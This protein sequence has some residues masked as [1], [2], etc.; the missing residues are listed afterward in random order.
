MKARVYRI[1]IVTTLTALVGLLVMQIYWFVHAYKLEEAQFDKSVNLA[2]RNVADNLLKSQKDF[3]GRIDPVQHTASNAFF[4]T[5][6]R[7]IEYALLDSLIRSE[8]KKHGIYTSFELGVYEHQS[9]V[10]LYGNFY[11]QGAL[12]E[13][14]ATC[15]NREP[16]VAKMDFSITFPDK[17]TDILGSLNIWI[18]TAAIFLLVLVVFSYMVM[19]L[20]KQKKLAEIKTDF[21]NNMTHELQTPIANIG[22]ASE[23]LRAVTPVDSKKAMRYAN[24]IHEEN[25]RL[26]FHVEQ[27]L[28]TAQ[29]ERGEVNLNKKEIDINQLINSVISN[30]ELRL[31]SRQGKIIKHLLA[32]PAQL[33]GDPFHLTN[34]FYNLLDN[35]DKYSPLNPEITI[36][37]RNHEAGIQISIADK[38]IGIKHDVQKFIF[39][40]FYRAATG[41]QHDIKGFGLGLTYVQQ[42]VK[43]HNG[44]VTVSSEENQGSRFDLYFQ[45]Y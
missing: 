11:Q 15:R 16:V 12:T 36:T 21:L 13:G 22:M 30:F 10:L 38:G 17:R 23:V 7:K 25:Q 35:A 34:L 9:N 14:D 18:I 37:T 45:S 41:N 43:A 26:K 3:S 33:T 32:S 6:N 42:I 44:I 5:L 24:I 4:V 31:Q 8:F 28:Q 39:D 27:V 40:K 2:L 20:S 1:L 29:M 19:D